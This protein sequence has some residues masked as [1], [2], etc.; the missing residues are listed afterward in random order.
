MIK[1]LMFAALFFIIIAASGL[2]YLNVKGKALLANAQRFVENKLSQSFN[3]KVAVD[4]VQLNIVGPVVLNGLSLSKQVSHDTVFVFKS[5][6]VIIYTD[7]LRIG[8]NKFLRK[9]EIADKDFSFK[10]ENGFLYRGEQPILRNINGYGKIVNNIFIFDDLNG[11][12]YNFPISVH[13]QSPAGGASDKKKVWV[14]LKRKEGVVQSVL[15][16]SKQDILQG[17]ILFNHI[18]A[19]KFGLYSQLD[20]ELDFT[21]PGKAFGRLKSGGTILGHRPFKELEGDFFVED[22][23]LVITAL[24]LGSDYILSG[25]MGLQKPYAIDL[26]LDIKDSELSQFL[27]VSDNDAEGKIAG[28]INGF[29][30]TKGSIDDLV[31]VAKLECSS[32]RLGNLDYES[33]NV[34]L[35]GRGSVLKVVDSRILRK[36]GFIGLSGEVDIKKL[37]SEEPLK[38]LAWACGNEAIIWNGWD[39]L[40][41]TNSQELEMKKGIG[42]QKEFIVTFK[43]YLNDEQSWQDSQGLRQNE[44][45][46]VEYNLDEAKRVKMQL[47]NNEEVFS[48]EHKVR[49]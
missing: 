10:I 25:S 16:F 48:L 7:L 26:T 21:K 6:K 15:D 39:I 24:R 35:H 4:S 12:C 8:I 49:F 22:S 34:N 43:G 5:E 30:K 46:G 11:R 47:K 41:Q 44:S 29:V 18:Y 14:E 17:S 38:G 31:T 9:G 3:A 45:V 36:E 20:F 28:T 33:M 1:R 2:T 37:W 42:L 32:G 13:S 23:V 19:G 40:K 27:L